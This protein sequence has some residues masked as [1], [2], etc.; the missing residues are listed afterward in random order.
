MKV[1]IYGAGSIGNHLA[2]ACRTK[3]WDVIMCDLDRDALE[4]TKNEIYPSRYGAWDEKIRLA[5]P[6]EVAD[7]KSDLVIVGTP[8][9][10]HLK[11]A[12]P[13]LENNPPRAMIIEKPLCKPDLEGIDRLNELAESTGCFVGVGYNHVLTENT[14]L[15]EEA[16]K[17]GD[18]G[19]AITLTCLFREHWGGI[20]GA[21]PWLDGP[22]DTYLGYWQRGGGASGEH[23]HAINLWQNFSHLV[24][25]GRIVKVSATLDM[26]NDGKAEYDRI[27]QISVTTEGGMVGLIVQDVVTEPAKKELRL[28]CE[29]GYIEWYANRPAGADSLIVANGGDPVETVIN[30]SRPDDFKGEIDHIEKILTKGGDSPISVIRGSETMMVIRAA[31]ESHRLGRSVTIDYDKGF[32]PGAIKA[33]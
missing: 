22:S 6:A 19:E 7:E 24:G 31:Q 30:K 17:K 14:R 8:P 33:L 18:L 20:F 32:T 26:V 3:G 27:C 1:V 21:H 13:I 16:I 10:T 5:E 9:D 23:S 11:I 28:Q 25:K 15:A 29:N 2:N 4:R 12:I